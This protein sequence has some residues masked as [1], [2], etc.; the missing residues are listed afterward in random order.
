V[1]SGG[2]PLIRKTHIFSNV[3][4]CF[5]IVYYCSTIVPSLLATAIFWLV[6]ATACVDVSKLTIWQDIRS[7]KIV[8]IQVDASY[9]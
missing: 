4:H 2:I 3:A 6:S 7:F 5:D 9:H 1:C 8:V